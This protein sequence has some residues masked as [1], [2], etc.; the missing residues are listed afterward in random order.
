MESRS[1][2]TARLAIWG[3][4]VDVHP[5]DDDKDRTERQFPRVEQDRYVI[6]THPSAKAVPASQTFFI[7][8]GDC[9]PSLPVSSITKHTCLVSPG[10]SNGVASNTL[11]P[12]GRSLRELKVRPGAGSKSILEKNKGAGEV[13]WMWSSR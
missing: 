3:E 11:F 13:F 8:S 9:P 1:D 7:P 4:P 10:L 6:P 2:E 5:A 12:S